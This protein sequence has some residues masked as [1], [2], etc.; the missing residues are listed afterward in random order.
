MYMRSYTQTPPCVSQA[1]GPDNLFFFLRGTPTLWVAHPARFSQGAIWRAVRNIC[2]ALQWNSVDAG[3]LRED[4]KECF[5]FFSPEGR[6]AAAQ[7]ASVE[8][9]GLAVARFALH[10]ACGSEEL[11][12]SSSQLQWRLAGFGVRD[13]QSSVNKLYRPARRQA[14]LRRVA[15][16]NLLF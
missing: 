15:H 4:T 10:S 12:P 5:L 1:G 13:C 14:V 3:A 9:F 8:C 7:S 11:A 6:R 2:N 16:P